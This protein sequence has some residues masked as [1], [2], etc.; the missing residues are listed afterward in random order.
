MINKQQW[1]SALEAQKLTGIK[2]R[3]YVIKYI[4]EGKLLAIQT[5]VNGRRIRYAILGS[6]INDFINRYKKGLVQGKQYNKKE[7]K[8]IL[9]KALR[10]LEK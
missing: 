5:G 4:N 1:Y 2:S 8:A 7:V 3:Q 9:E 10:N 6:W